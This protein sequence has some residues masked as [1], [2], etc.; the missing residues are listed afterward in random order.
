MLDDSFREDAIRSRGFFPLAG[1]LRLA[2]EVEDLD[3]PTFNSV[4]LR[5]LGGL[6]DGFVSD[7]ASPS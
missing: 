5:E 1:D 6:E 4:R 3:L 7:F 2:S